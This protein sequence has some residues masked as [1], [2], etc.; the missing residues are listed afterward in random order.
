MSFLARSPPIRFINQAARSP[1]ALR[2]F[3]VSSTQQK[4][5]VDTTKDVLKKVDRKVSDK[6]V[7]GFEVAR[8]TFSF[9]V[10]FPGQFPYQCSREGNQGQQ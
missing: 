10:Y 2:T 9:P 1:Y 5:V 3:S 4:S 6:L 8:K 7:D